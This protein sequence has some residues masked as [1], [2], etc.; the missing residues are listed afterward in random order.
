MLIYGKSTVG[1][2]YYMGSYLFGFLFVRD[3]RNLSH[4]YL[5]CLI[6]STSTFEHGL[7]R[8]LLLLHSLSQICSMHTFSHI[9][10]CYIAQATCSFP[11]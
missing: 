7:G 8:N 1:D 5:C 11:A 2:V 10:F 6:W 9:Y 4:I 3:E